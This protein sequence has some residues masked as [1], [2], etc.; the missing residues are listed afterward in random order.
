MQVTQQVRE[1]RGEPKSDSEVRQEGD[2]FGRGRCSISRQGR[3]GCKNQCD[4]QCFAQSS[5]QPIGGDKDTCI[6]FDRERKKGC[7]RRLPCTEDHEY[8]IFWL[9]DL[10]E[11]ALALDTE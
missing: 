11:P 10:F 4:P 9:L 8:A 1:S 5:G 3:C 6:V 2:Q 7:L